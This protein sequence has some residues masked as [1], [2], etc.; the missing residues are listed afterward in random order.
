MMNKITSK[1]GKTMI[2]TLLVMGILAFI[3]TYVVFVGKQFQ[4]NP[5]GIFHLMRFESI[6]QALAAG[7]WPSRINFIGYEHQG[8]AVTGMYPWLSAWMFILPRFFASPMW[9]FT[10]GFLILNFMTIGFTWLLMGR[11]TDK[12]LIKWLGV[13]LYQFNGYHFILMYS[14]V[15]LGEAIGYMALPLV[16]LGLIDIWQNRKYGWAV[17]G[18]GMAIIANGHMLSLLMCTVMVV[19]FEAGRLI[20]KKMSVAE[21]WA[22]IKAALLAGVLSAYTLFTMLQIMMQNTLMPPNIR[23]DA[24]TGHH[25][26]L[27]TLTNDFKEYRDTTMGLVI[28]IVILVFLII[29]IKNFKKSWARWIFAANIVFLCTFD[30]ILG[31]ELVNTPFANIQ[32]SMR[33]L[34]FVAMF[35]AIGIV[36]YFDERPLNVPTKVWAWIIIVTVMIGSLAGM[37]EYFIKADQGDYTHPLT[38]KT[39]NKRISKHGVKDYV[40]RD[41]SVDFKDIDF[42]KPDAKE[43]FFAAMLYDPDVKKNFK[44]KKSTFDSVTW[45]QDTKTAGDTKL[46]VVGYNGIDYTVRVNGATVPYERKEGH[47]FVT[48]PAGHN[49]ITISGR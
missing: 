19:V 47:L 49:E 6:Y 34:M 26:I 10:I 12:T 37:R 39:Y 16:I 18:F 29:A 13:I 42:T 14:R 20:M 17:L 43:K 27:A 22:I 38:A 48:L 4:I 2:G 44:H 1:Q 35:L 45:T 46:P 31:P 25:Y 3:S 36:M 28:G 15:A 5:D 24:L 7:Q 23:W 33:F 8:A 30:F 11:F 21:F 32:F 41:P 9:S 40:L